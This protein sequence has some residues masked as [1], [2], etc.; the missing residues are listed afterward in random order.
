MTDDGTDQNLWDALGLT[1]ED[2]SEPM[3]EGVWEAAIAHA[4]DP[5]TPEVDAQLV[6]GAGD[7]LMTGD[8]L[9]GEI[10]VDDLDQDWNGHHDTYG[11]GQDE[12]PDDI[13]EPDLDA[14]AGTDGF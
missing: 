14:D 10:I 9:D 1:P 6:P 11:D 8:D 3:P 2:V 4:V 7:E 12:V 13:D 5:N